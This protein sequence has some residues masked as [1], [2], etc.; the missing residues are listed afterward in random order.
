LPTALSFIRIQAHGVQVTY[1]WGFL[2]MLF[3]YL[4]ERLL[5]LNEVCVICDQTHLFA[6]GNMLKPAVC[7]RELC[8]WS[9]QQLKVGADS[10]EDVA[11]EAEV[12]DLLM[13]MA[14]ISAKSARKEL[15]FNPFPTVYALSYSPF[16]IFFFFCDAYSL[17][18]QGSTQP[19]RI[20]PC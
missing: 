15:I 1:E 9:F 13:S 14:V 8:C 2:V 10:A 7:S 4:R 20:S 19:N 5:K 6:T 16:Y 3:T 18:P 12:I 11:T 17:C